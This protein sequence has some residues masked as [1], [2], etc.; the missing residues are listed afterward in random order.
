MIR[1]LLLPGVIIALL[2]AGLDT[3]QWLRASPLW[4]DEEMIALNV[5]DRPFA[6]LPGALWL[7]QSA[8]LGWLVIERAAVLAFGT[9][10]LVLR[11]VPL[12]FGI[13][14]LAAAAWVGHRWMNWLGAA[15]L[16]ICCAIAQWLSHYRF[17]V[18]HYSADAFWA[19]LLPAM[20]AWA[21]EEAE[22]EP[23]HRRWTRWWAVAALAQWVANGALLVTP[24]C[25]LLLGAV[26]MRRDGARAAIRFAA[27]G[28]LW[29]VSVGVHYAMS[30]QYAHYSRHLRDYWAPY[31][32]PESADLVQS[33][34]W[35]AGRLEPLA[36]HPG[37]T[38]LTAALW[39]AAFAGFVFARRRLLGVMFASVPLAGFAL[40]LLRLVPLHDR[41]AVWIVPALYG[42]VALAAD[43][44]FHH[45]W[46]AWRERKWPWAAPSVLAIAIAIYVSTDILTTGYRHLD[47]D[48]PASGNHALDDRGAVRWLMQRRQPGDALLSTRLGWPAIWWYG[49]INLRRPAP[50]ARL[51]DG[52]VMYVLTDDGPPAGCET[53]LQ[54]ALAPHP[55]AL[56]YVGFPDMPKGFYDTTVQKLSTL[57]TVVESAE[58]SDI[59]RTA[60][61]DLRVGAGRV[62]PKPAAVD[63]PA[64]DATDA[65]IGVRLARRW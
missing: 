60:V 6:E 20:A 46:R 28:S 19:F 57:G 63:A 49:G 41:L 37:G 2:A 40:A 59:G 45:G 65:C 30:L 47:L 7:G 14:T 38:M 43:A 1:A 32:A 31:V 21:A 62:P 36:S 48:H 50:G 61:I 27:T 26:I 34:Q 15:L 53:R 64:P 35:I 39:T 25:A 11:L 8:P 12:L 10:E 55:R 16:T 17:E 22:P 56:L 58:F 9:G 4:V 44:G 18:K 29:L 51:A 54:N 33:L 42:G 3:W 13:A 23:A 52:A 5:R 24:A